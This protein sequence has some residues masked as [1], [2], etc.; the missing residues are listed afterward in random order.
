MPETPEAA[1]SAAL[2]DPSRVAALRA[3]YLLDTP[4]EQAFDRLAH[5]AAKALGVPAAAICLFDRDRLFFKSGVGDVFSYE[6][7]QGAPPSRS[8]CQHVVAGA[9]PLAVGDARRHPGLEDNFAVRELGVVAYLG[10]PLTTEEGHVLGTFC[11]FDSAPRQW[12]EDQADLL[13]SLASAA[14]SL[15]EYRAAAPARGAG[16][17]PDRDG[18]GAFLAAADTLAAAA[19]DHAEALDAYDACTRAARTG[20]ELLAFEAEH[21]ARVIG[22]QRGLEGAVR[23]VPPPPAG[24]RADEPLVRAGTT[25]L[26]ACETYLEAEARRAETG[27]R[28]RR[29][30]AALQDVEAATLAVFRAEK[31]VRRAVRDYETGREP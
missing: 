22:T 21:R 25:L 16:A 14:V 17:E 13:L 12:R 31:G 4:P 28:F 20:P 6:R 24:A 11:A 30:E 27:D 7:C 23:A 15:A 8:L 1:V 18:V 9:K 3:M 10:V 5:V 29:L 19:S 2:S 26:R